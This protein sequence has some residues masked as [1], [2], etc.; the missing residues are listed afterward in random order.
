MGARGARW[1]RAALAA[2]VLS[3][4]C[5]GEADRANELRRRFPDAASAVLTPVG[6]PP[7]RIEG[8]ATVLA[9]PS[10][11]MALIAERARD[12]G[13]RVRLDDG[14]STFEVRVLEVEVRGAPEI[15]EHAVALPRRNGTSYWTSTDRG[16]EEWLALEPGAANRGIVATWRIEGGSLRARGSVVD[17]VDPAGVA[18]LTVTADQAQ[19]LSGRPVHASL[20]VQ[21][22]SLALTVDATDE[23]VLIDPGWIPAAS[24]L[25]QSL[26]LHTAT[27]ISTGELLVA[28]GGWGN[29]V[30]AQTELYDPVADAWHGGAPL[31]TARANHTATL[32]NDGR[33]L[34][35]GGENQFHEV[36]FP[37]EIYDP[38]GGSWSSAGALNGG[39]TYHTAT[40]LDDGRVLVA[41]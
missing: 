7:P 25:M 27:L 40:L 26:G 20:S 8:D 34:V 36:V 1:A 32:L 5:G 29:Q 35:A 3:T 18:R 31:A 33:V 15:I 6:A 37:A 38:I 22:T 4:S 16:L 39:R 30:F 11:R 28:G 9:R 14:G 41:V 21:G 19:T 23:A 13:V 10:A 17:V 12:A 2:A 24:T